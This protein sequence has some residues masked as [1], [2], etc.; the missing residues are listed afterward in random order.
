MNYQSYLLP[1]I[2]ILFF[3]YKFLRNKQI[4][5]K[6]PELMKSGAT[7]IDVRSPEEFKAGH[8]PISKNIPLNQLESE[9]KKLNKDSSFVLCCASG[10]RSGMALAIFKRHGFKN[11][12]NGGPWS[13]TL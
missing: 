11:V 8:N 6:M 13:N 3:A 1:A 12:H 9:I 4:K 5:K 7:I 2:I 10:A